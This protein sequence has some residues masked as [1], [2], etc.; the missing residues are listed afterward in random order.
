MIRKN[1]KAAPSG[2]AFRSERDS[3]RLYLERPEKRIE[4][5]LLQ[6]FLFHQ[7]VRDLL[8]GFFVLPQNALRDG[9]GLM[10][11][12]V[13]LVVDLRSHLLRV[14]LF[15]RDLPAQEDKLLGLAESDRTELA[16]AVFGDQPP[17][18]SRGFLEIVRCAGGYVVEGQ[19]L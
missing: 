12:L 5:F 8:Q 17:R 6:G 1:K 9:V 3:D 10:E 13:H 4:L 14:V 7:H 11:Y 19:L 16:H 15:G 18:K 2:A